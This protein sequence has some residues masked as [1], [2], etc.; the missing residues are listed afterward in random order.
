[1][2]LLNRG[3]L[4]LC[5]IL[6]GTVTLAEEPVVASNVQ[7]ALDLKPNTCV[8]LHQGQRCFVNV[9]AT[10]QSRSK[11][12]YCLYSSAQQEA[13]KCWVKSNHGILT[14]QLNSQQTV[15]FYLKERGTDKVIAKA[16]LEVSWVYKKKQKSNVTWRLF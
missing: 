3:C 4:L 11:R 13:I 5:C 10:W 8:S 2:R 12:D 1:M 16:T 15:Q 14:Q 7:N 6:P 9:T